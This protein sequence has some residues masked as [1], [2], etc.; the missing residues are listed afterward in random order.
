MTRC[1]DS[2]IPEPAPE[3][4]EGQLARA[5][6]EQCAAQIRQYWLMRGYEVP[7]M[8][9]GSRVVLPPF[10]NGRP[11]PEMKFTVAHADVKN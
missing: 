2:P 9:V 10:P 1:K 7:V 3:S 5:T 8:I 6:A 11:P 4:L